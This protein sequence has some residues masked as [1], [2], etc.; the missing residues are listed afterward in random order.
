M[1]DLTKSEA[2]ANM[3]NGSFVSHKSAPD[4]GFKL[5]RVGNIESHHGE[6]YSAAEFWYARLHESFDSGW[7]LYKSE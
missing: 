1:G 3:A 5:S 2:Q 4:I 7:C 6:V